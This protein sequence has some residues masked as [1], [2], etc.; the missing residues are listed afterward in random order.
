MRVA[1][2][3][4]TEVRA[5]SADATISEVVERLAEAHITAL[6]VAEGHDRLIGVVSTTDILEAEAA[7]GGQRE[8]DILFDSTTARELMTPRPLTIGPLADLKEAARDMLYAE[9]RRLFVETDGKLV[10]VITEGD[11]VR[12]LALGGVP[13]GG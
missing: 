10:G 2:V 8:R 6:P 11:I 5:I 9:I 4:Q 3:M 13:S 7:A 12:A 1:D